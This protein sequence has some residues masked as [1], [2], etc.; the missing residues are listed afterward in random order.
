MPQVLTPAL[1]IAKIPGSQFVIWQAGALYRMD[2][3][4]LIAAGVLGLGTANQ[5][6][7]MNAGGTALE[8]KPPYPIV[9]PFVAYTPAFSA[10]FGTVTGVSIWSRRVGDSANIRGRF[11]AGTPTAAEAQMSMGFNGTSGNIT[12]DAT[13]VVAG[14][15]QACGIVIRGAAV[16][17]TYVGLIES[18]VTYITFGASNAA[19]TANPLTKL[20]GSG[21]IGAGNIVSVDVNIPISGWT[22]N[23]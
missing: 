10:S 11:T 5:I 3:P 6:L 17:I 4:A 23:S 13:K 8:W 7:G 20:A 21:F 2:I 22:A 15:T 12:S 18:G 14:S 16:A 1:E 19:G 9:T